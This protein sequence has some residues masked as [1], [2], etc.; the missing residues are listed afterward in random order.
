M[1]YALG[2]LTRICRPEVLSI[3]YVESIP[4]YGLIF[5]TPTNVAN[6]N[7]VCPPKVVEVDWILVDYYL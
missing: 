3:V 4:R 1:C 7:S 5:W 6:C 2:R